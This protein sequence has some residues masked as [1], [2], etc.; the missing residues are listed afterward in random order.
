MNV[1]IRVPIGFMFFM[2]GVLLT[3]YGAATSGNAEPYAKSLGYNINLW[4]G[5]ALL[6]FGGSFLLLGWLSSR[7][8]KPEK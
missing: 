5:L 4:W 1:D 3:G 2:I 8:A 7:N 6:L